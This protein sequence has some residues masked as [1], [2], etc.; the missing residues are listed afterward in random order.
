MSMPSPSSALLEDGAHIRH[1]LMRV[2]DSRSLLA[3][4]IAQ[5]SD[6]Y[7]SLIVELDLRQGAMLL[8]ELHPSDGANAVQPGSQLRVRTRVEGSALEFDCQVEQVMSSQGAKAYLARIPERVRYHERRESFRVS[9]PHDFALPPAIFSS[10]SGAF[11]G[12]LLDIS[13]TGVGTLVSDASLTG[14]GGRVACTLSLPGTRLI[15]DVQ[16]R[17]LGKSAGVPRMGVLFSQLSNV[18]KTAMAK[19]VAALNRDL[20]RRYASARW[21]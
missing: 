18:Q 5:R 10:A 7:T 3:T 6:A 4:S 16:V 9:I 2:M 17:S 20:L 12:R 15:T 19:A 8:D 21:V 11:R 14:V 13:E 1:L